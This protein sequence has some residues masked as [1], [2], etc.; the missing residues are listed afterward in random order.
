MIMKGI[1]RLFSQIC[2]RTNPG[3]FATI[4]HYFSPSL[5][6]ILLFLPLGLS[7]QT[8]TI[9]SGRSKALVEPLIQKFE[10]EHGVR[11]NVRYGSSTQLA[12][13]MLEEG[14]R[15]PADV[16]WAQDAGALGAVHRGDMFQE[17]PSDLLTMLPEQLH[18]SEGTWIATSGRA[19]VMA[20]STSRVDTTDLPNSIFGL[21]DP[22]WRGRVGWAPSNGSFQSFLTSVRMIE[23]DDTTLQWLREMKDN[24]A[25][26][27]INNSALLQ[28]IAA[29]EI[30]VALTNHYY[31]FRFRENNPQFPVDQTYFAPGDPGNLVNVAG[32]GILSNARDSETALRFIRFLLEEENQQW[33]TDEVYEYPVRRDIRATPGRSFQ[34]IQELSPSLDLDDLSDLDQTL[35]LLRRADLL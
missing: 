26:S 33:V 5:F 2:R 6:L 12:V 14:S 16:F 35:Q 8:L 11:M 30:D 3:L 9:Y 13:A 10:A 25:Q 20:Y 4:R 23:G 29:G 34:D 21:T 22:K 17:L 1:I 27:Y 7:A 32:I 24:G 19:R 18:N 15:T 28:A 31:L